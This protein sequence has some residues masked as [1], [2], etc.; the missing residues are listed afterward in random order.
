VHGDA[1]HVVVAQLALSGMGARAQFQAQRAGGLG[2]GQ[3]AAQRLGRSVEGGKHPVA[4]GAHAPAAV[5][6][7]LSLD[8]LVVSRQQFRPPAIAQLGGPLR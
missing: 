6:G 1:G 3:R 5:S 8:Q 2:Q 4:G 7:E